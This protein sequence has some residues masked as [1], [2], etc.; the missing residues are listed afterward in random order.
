VNTNEYD[1][2]GG[3]TEGS[4]YNLLSGN[5]LS[6]LKMD[7][8]RSAFLMAPNELCNGIVKCVLKM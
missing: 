2:S 8:V 3:E 1:K 5:F 7:I 6:P 4:E